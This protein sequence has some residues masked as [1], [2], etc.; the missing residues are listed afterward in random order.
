METTKFFGFSEE[1]M[2][3]PSCKE[4]FQTGIAGYIHHSQ[5]SVET[6]KYLERRCSEVGIPLEYL[7]TWLTST[8]GRHFCDNFFDEPL[9]VQLSLCED[10]LV[11]IHNLGLVYSDKSHRGSL[12]DSIRIREKRSGELWTSLP[13]SK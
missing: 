2:N 11:A 3:H 7:A 6:D 9:D 8:D 10:K 4:Y 1:V 13:E 12:R 5:R